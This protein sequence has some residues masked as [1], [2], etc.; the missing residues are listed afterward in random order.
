MVSRT[1]HAILAVT[2]GFS[3]PLLIPLAAELRQRGWRVTIV[4]APEEKA[5]DSCLPE[6]VVAEHI[7]MA[8][9]IS[10][11][12]D[13]R[14]LIQWL[15]FLSRTQPD[16]VVAGTP[17][18]GF[19][20]MLASFMRGVGTR[21]YVLRGLRLE[22]ESGILKIILFLLE[23]LTAQLAHKVLAVSES[24]RRKYEKMKLA[25]PGKMVVLGRGSSKGVNLEK[26]RPKR[27]SDIERVLLLQG[28]VGLDPSIPTIGLFG[29][30]SRDKGYENF[31]KAIDSKILHPI[32][33]QVLVVGPDETF[34]G[35]E[36]SMTIATKKIVHVTRP[37]EMTLHYHAITVLCLPTLREGFPNVALEAQ[38]SGVPVITT[39]ATGAV[40]SVAD[41]YSGLVVNKDRP[42]DLAWGL[43]K[44]L[45]DSW[46][47]EQMGRNA[48]AW[49]V[50]NF[51]EEW[52]ISQQSDFIETLCSG[53]RQ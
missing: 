38:A 36:K 52:V 47:L 24:L 26:F 8:R 43:R 1:K 6:G 11:F 53:Q 20:G 10:P 48:R 32:S 33:F 7:E 41:G 4:S 3:V 14:A 25:K 37:D 39:D 19:L 40:D 9:G 27:E 22:T 23:G 17:K 35:W 31:L 50:D 13:L 18:A 12:R 45:T 15:R 30:I 2:V 28:R 5:V 34:G 44:L 49:A 42:D 51:Q 16:I 21:V 46:T 29:R